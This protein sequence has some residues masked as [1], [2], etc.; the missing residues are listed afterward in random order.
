M[1]NRNSDTASDEP[2]ITVP[3]AAL[4]ALVSYAEAAKASAD[5]EYVCTTAEQDESDR[6]LERVLT[7]LGVEEAILRGTTT[8]DVSHS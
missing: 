6:E 2:T 4:L 3:L 1:V 8:L 5:S 7:A